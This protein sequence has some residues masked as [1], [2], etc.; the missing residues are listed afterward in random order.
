V[1]RDD[2]IA[3]ILESG[4]QTRR[5]TPRGLWIA[6]IVIGAI[7]AAGFAVAMLAPRDPTAHVRERRDVERHGPGLGLGLVIGVA[8]GIAIG[9]VAGMSIERRRRR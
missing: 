3:A 8:A 2:D 1:G 7:C 5:R 6:A 4:R 9:V